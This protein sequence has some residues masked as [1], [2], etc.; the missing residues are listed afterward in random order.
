MLRQHIQDRFRSFAGFQ[1]RL[2]ISDHGVEC[3]DE[4]LLDILIPYRRGLAARLAFFVLAVAAPD[5]APVGVVGVPDLHAVPGSAVTAFYLG[6]EHALPAV[7]IPDLFS[8]CQF[9]LHRVPLFRDNDCFVAVLDIVL[10][11]LAFVDFSALSQKVSREALLTRV[12]GFE[13]PK[14]T[15]DLYGLALLRRSGSCLSGRTKI[16]LIEPNKSTSTAL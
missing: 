15:R 4:P 1:V 9:V 12:T 16:A 2:L 14:G 13:L 6:T 5:L 7:G 8:P 10:G 3:R 11:N